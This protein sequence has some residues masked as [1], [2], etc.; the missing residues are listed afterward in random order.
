M[1]FPVTSNGE[2]ALVVTGGILGPPK[3]AMAAGLASSTRSK[4]V[5]EAV[6]FMV[7]ASYFVNALGPP[8]MISPASNWE[9]PKRSRMARISSGVISEC[10]QVAP[11]Q[12]SSVDST[13]HYGCC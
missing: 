8:P 2:D 10:D 9:R 11:P 1:S 4:L 12:W 3:V 5:T 6:G 13:D 7:P